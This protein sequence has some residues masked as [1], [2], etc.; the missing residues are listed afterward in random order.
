MNKTR[1]F[2]MTDLIHRRKTMIKS[3]ILP[4]ICLLAFSACAV[5]SF[6]PGHGGMEMNMNL[7]LSAMNMR[8]GWAVFSSPTKYDSKDQDSIAR[9]K[10][11]FEQH[12]QKCH[13]VTGVG[14]GPK[15]S[16]LNK[17]PANLKNISHGTSNTYLIVQ[18]NDGKGE[19]P[20]W[21]DFLSERETV[22]LTNYI[23]TLKD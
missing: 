4:S 9:G 1:I 21:Q 22:D 17:K 14:N 13:G 20:R 7:D 10:A 15:A 6:A 12:C 19:M 3:I 8:H 11:L 23:R 16:A 2:K 18:I 5:R